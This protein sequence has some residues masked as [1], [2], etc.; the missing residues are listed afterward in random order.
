MPS[1]GTLKADTLTHSTAGSL[2][3]N[4]VVNG[5]AKAFIRANQAS[6]SEGQSF[7]VSSSTD[8][9]TGDYSHTLTNSLTTRGQLVATI[10]R[11]ANALS[12]AMN[13]SRDSASIMAVRTYTASSATDSRAVMV[14]FGDLA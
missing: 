11:N 4:Y 5:S 12:I 10:R 7:N 13:E 14:Y 3:T 9:G 8:H 1:F 6:T 2:D